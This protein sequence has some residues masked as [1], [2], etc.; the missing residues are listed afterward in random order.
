MQ[1]DEAF[2]IKLEYHDTLNPKLWD[3]NAHLDPEVRQKLLEIASEWQESAK[4]PQEA[5]RDIVITGGNVNYNY[6]EQSDIDVHFLYA[7]EHMPIKDPDILKDYFFAKKDIWARKHKILV[8]GYPIELFAEPADK[9][10]PLGQGVYSIL[11]DH[12]IQRA[13]HQNFDWE[14]DTGLR[15]DVYSNVRQINKILKGQ[16]PMDLAQ[17][18]AER[19]RASR[20]EA[21]QQ[22]GEF[23]RGQL[24][25]KDLRNRGYLQ[26]LS[27]Y[28][29]KAK[30]KKLSL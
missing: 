14:H 10:H 8:K 22:D 30:D 26:K 18:F 6:T 20:G 29:L 17:Q 16:V 15:K 7:P 3:E 4:I 23:A 2:H 19:L 27:D 9:I 11:H 25:F 12:W 5:I 28:I 24:V 21:I 1:I 13:E